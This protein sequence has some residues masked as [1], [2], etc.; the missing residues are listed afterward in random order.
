MKRFILIMLPVIAMAVSMTGCEPDETITNM[1]ESAYLAQLEN[2]RQL[3]LAAMQQ[4]QGG[5]GGITADQV[6][7]LIN[8][9]KSSK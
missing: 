6:K 5:Q 1:P 7:D 9:A 8:T 2:Q 3:S 4:T